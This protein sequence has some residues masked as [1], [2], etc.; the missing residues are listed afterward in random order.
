MNLSL[1]LVERT[2]TYKGLKN[3]FSKIKHMMWR[4]WGWRRKIGRASLIHDAILII[5]ATTLKKEWAIIKFCQEKK[6]RGEKKSY[7][8][9]TWWYIIDGTILKTC[10]SLGEEMFN[11][12]GQIIEFKKKSISTNCGFH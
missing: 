11:W 3:T 5:Q 7:G 12:C 9:T 10:D 1:N 2:H 4:P 6:G 8:R